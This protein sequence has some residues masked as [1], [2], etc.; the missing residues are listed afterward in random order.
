M[1]TS[2][3]ISKIPFVSFSDFIFLDIWKPKSM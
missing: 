3:G 2:V 1:Q